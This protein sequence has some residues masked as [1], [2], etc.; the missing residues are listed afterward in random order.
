MMSVPG[1]REFVMENAVL[2]GK[3]DEGVILASMDVKQAKELFMPPNAT[4]NSAKRYHS[5][6]PAKVPKKKNEE[7]QSSE[8][9]Q[10]TASQVQQGREFTSDPE[11]E[12]Y[13]ARF[14]GDGMNKLKVGVLAV[15]RYHQIRRRHGIADQPNYNDHDFP[16][17]GYLLAPFG[18]MFTAKPRS[19]YAKQLELALAKFQVFADA[20]FEKQCHLLVQGILVLWISH[21][22][23]RHVGCSRG[24]QSFQTIDPD[25]WLSPSAT[26]IY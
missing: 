10:T 3:T 8:D 12:K 15:S 25:L 6:I 16:F 21:S 13:C 22:G 2:D 11:F 20:E 26:T 7:A 1:L 9:F 4:H 24:D 23:R 18:L 5:A 17:P 14:S 19:K